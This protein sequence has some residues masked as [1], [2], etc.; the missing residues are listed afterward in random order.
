MKIALL[1]TG[2]EDKHY[3]YVRWLKANENIEVVK[4]SAE[5]DNL[6]ELGGCDALV[7]SGGRDVHPKAYYSSRT[8]YPHAPDYFDE[9]RDEF[10]TAAFWQAQERGLPVLGI[11]RGMQLI[12]CIMEGTLHQDLGAELNQTHHGKAGVDEPHE[13]RVVPHTLLHELVP[14]GAARV[15]SS[16]HQAVDQLGK[17]LRVNCTAADGT[18]EGFE[19]ASRAGKPFL[20]GVQWHPERMFRRQWEDA[21]LAMGIRNLFLE[22]IRQSKKLHEN[23]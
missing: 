8:S 17:G 23:H 5:D 16:H 13:V 20:L 19:W 9:T 22:A 2:S 12:N 18:I 11:C 4:L 14:G 21:P 15:V 3:N 6:H 1:Y 10:E 7:M